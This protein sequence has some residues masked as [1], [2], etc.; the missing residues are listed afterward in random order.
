VP[1]RV[2]SLSPSASYGVSLYGSLGTIGLRLSSSLYALLVVPVDIR[3]LFA[4]AVTISEQ[5]ST[6]TLRQMRDSLD[7]LLSST[8]MTPADGSSCSCGTC[9]TLNRDLG[10]SGRSCR[11]CGLTRFGPD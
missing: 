7:G 6:R 1:C 5:R 3:M 2:L 8:D 11:S 9:R 10:P 4:S